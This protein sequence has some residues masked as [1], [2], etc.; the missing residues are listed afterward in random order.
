MDEEK[1]AHIRGREQRLF[2]AETGKV[3]QVYKVEEAQSLTLSGQGEVQ[4]ENDDSEWTQ[5]RRRRQ[6]HKH[7]SLP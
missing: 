1:E 3:N 4:A 6:R 2:K 7:K 5:V